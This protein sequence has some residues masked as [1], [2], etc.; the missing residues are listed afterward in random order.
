MFIDIQIKR[1]EFSRDVDGLAEL[2]AEMR[3]L[4]PAWV[5]IYVTLKGD[6]IAVE[7]H[8]VGKEVINE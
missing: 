4:G 1:Y 3:K 6:E 8:R 7:L 2:V 5:I